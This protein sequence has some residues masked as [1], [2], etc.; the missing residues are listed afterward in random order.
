MISTS[1]HS[2]RS[3]SIVSKSNSKILFNGKENVNFPTGHFVTIVR[4]FQMSLELK[5]IRYFL[6]TFTFIFAYLIFRKKINQNCWNRTGIFMTRQLK[7]VR[8]LTDWI[9]SVLLWRARFQRW[10]QSFRGARHKLTF[11]KKRNTR[12]GMDIIK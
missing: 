10:L 3:F 4:T 8:L 11:L 12:Y 2:F 1:K 7:W 5:K 6:D 9:T